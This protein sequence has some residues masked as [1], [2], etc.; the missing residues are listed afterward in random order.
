[1]GARNGPYKEDFPAGTVL[2][3]R[4]RSALERFRDEWRWHHQLAPEQL[5]Y[6]GQ[7]TVVKTVSFYHG[8]DE[9]YELEGVPGT[10][11]EQCLE[12]IRSADLGPLEVR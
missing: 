12:E 2:R 1:M 5:A 9:L 11:H 4:A 7:T 3:I 6:A 10:W 8:G